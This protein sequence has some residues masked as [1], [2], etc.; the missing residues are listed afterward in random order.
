MR[1]VVETIR[2][3][4]KEFGADINSRDCIAYTALHIAAWKGM[5]TPLEH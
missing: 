4:I 3:L 1:G 5:W 2:T